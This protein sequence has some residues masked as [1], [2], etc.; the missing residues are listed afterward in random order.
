MLA[1][2]S[3]LSFAR[4]RTSSSWPG[5]SAS[6]SC[7]FRRRLEDMDLGMSLFSP[8]LFSIVG[9]RTI[10]RGTT[11][12]RR[13]NVEIQDRW[14]GHG[15]LRGCGSGCR[16]QDTGRRAR[17]GREP[18]R[19]VISRCL[20]SRRVRAGGPGELG[21]WG[22]FWSWSAWDPRFLVDVVGLAQNV[23]LLGTEPSWMRSTGKSGTTEPVGG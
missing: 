3:R 12:W 13:S 15:C 2:V 8:L 4:P 16:R 5:A 11:R 23:V 7:F 14:T 19:L 9:R 21:S 17:S 6:R 18:K 1:S 10:G 20:A 22:A